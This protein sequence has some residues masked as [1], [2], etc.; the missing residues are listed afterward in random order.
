MLGQW[1]KGQNG[2]DA[3]AEEL[4]NIG[5]SLPRLTWLISLLL[6]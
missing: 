4:S 1:A 6:V 5:L 2:L 3:K